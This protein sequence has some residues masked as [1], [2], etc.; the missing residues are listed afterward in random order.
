MSTK[1][2]QVEK[3][4]VKLTIEV[5]AAAFEEGMNKSFKKNAN[6]F[7]VQGFRKGKAPRNIVERVYGEYVLYDDAVNFVVPGAYDA[8]VAENGIVPVDRPEIDVEQIG[9]GQ[10]LI[11]TAVVTVK[12]E[13]KLGEYKG[14]KVKKAS[15][16]VTDEDVEEE[17]KKTAEK[18]ARLVSVTERPVKEQDTAYIDFEGFVDGVPFEGGKGENYPLV[19]GSG[20]FI[21]G[22]EEQLI[23]AEIGQ[24]TEV[25]VTF[26]EDYH[27][28][29]LKGKEAVFKCKVNEIKFKEL[30]VVDDDFIKDISEFDTVD[31]Y[32][33]DIKD[34]LEKAAAEK[35]KNENENN[36]IEAVSANAE[37]DVPKVMI[38][39][40]I[41]AHIRDLEQRLRYQGITLEQ[42]LSMMGSNLEEMRSRFAENSE[43]QV[44]AQLTIEAIGKA[45]GIESDEDSVNA[46]IEELAKNYKKEP[47]EIKNMLKE[48]D[49]SY[50]NEQ[51]IYE[52]TIKFIVDNAKFTK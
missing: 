14:I 28:E 50:M 20:S 37:I 25:K 43:K 32:K 33:A 34:K 46:K 18:N 23:G 22:F 4:V 29:D 36:V 49:Y 1:V 45:E 21:P 47:E 2:E 48:E 11:F 26:P 30:P 8:A 6:K 9:G 38:D 35:E 24:E 12:P 51:I 41:D 40:Q 3:N 7:S 19:I 5:D 42:Y 39:N 13:V 31:E 10:N 52:K 16:P 17:M 15:Y 27:S 44:R